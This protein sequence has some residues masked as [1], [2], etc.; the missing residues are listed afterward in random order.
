MA[1]TAPSFWIIS[2]PEGS[3]SGASP[4]PSSPWKCPAVRV[5]PR[6]GLEAPRN[7]GIWNVEPWRYYNPFCLSVHGPQTKGLFEGRRGGGFG[8]GVLWID[9]SLTGK[10][11]MTDDGW[12][13]Q[14]TQSHC[15]E[16]VAW[17]QQRNAAALKKILK[18][19]EEKINFTHCG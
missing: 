9:H 19:G 2:E 6:I 12:I 18:K 14:A 5:F 7:T 1:A 3:G 11:F 10:N 13:H 16:K 15:K 17:L 4:S 8:L